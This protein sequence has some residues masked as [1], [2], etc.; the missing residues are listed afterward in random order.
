NASTNVDAAD[1]TVTGTLSVDQSSPATPGADPTLA[2]LA[3]PIVSVPTAAL[4]P[5]IDVLSPLLLH[6][7]ATA[8]KLR[9]IVSSSGDG[10]VHVT[11]GSVDL[12]SPT[13][14]MGSNDLRFALP[15]SLLSAL[16]RSSAAGNVLTV[17]PVA[18]NGAATGQPV[19]RRVAVTP[20][21]K[22]GHR[23]KK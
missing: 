20:K 11:L 18:S 21:P 22:P 16:R 6:V 3:G 13:V 23:A 1:F 4:P 19:T 9:L 2:T 17:T 14:R 10:A 7:S 12:G 5:T 15:K 8:P